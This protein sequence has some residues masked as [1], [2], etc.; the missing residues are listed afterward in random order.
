MGGG[1][2]FAKFWLKRYDTYT[3]H[4]SWKKSHKFAKFQRKKMQIAKFL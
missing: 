1:C 2:N 3:K 4:F